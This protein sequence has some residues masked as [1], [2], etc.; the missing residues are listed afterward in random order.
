MDPREKEFM[1]VMESLGL[2]LDVDG[3]VLNRHGMAV[4]MET[5]NPEEWEQLVL[6][7]PEGWSI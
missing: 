5:M 3:T 4:S 6:A 7:L 1:E 2:H